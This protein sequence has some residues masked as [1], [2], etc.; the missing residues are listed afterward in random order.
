MAEATGS[1]RFRQCWWYAAIG[2]AVLSEL[3]GDTWTATA[4]TVAWFTGVVADGNAMMTGYHGPDPYF[5]AWT[6]RQ[7]D[8]AGL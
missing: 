1:D 2:A 6:A 5:H 8:V 3:T 4:G 7:F